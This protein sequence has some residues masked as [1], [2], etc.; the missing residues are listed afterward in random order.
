MAYRLDSGALERCGRLGDPCN[1][2]FVDN[3]YIAMTGVGVTITDFDV[4]VQGSLPSPGDTEQPRVT[5]VISGT[6][7]SDPDTDST[8]T[9]QT[10]I[11]QRFPDL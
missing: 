1:N 9:I 5:L 7:G 2:P 11:T 6:S 4:Y 8:F 10:T 3:E